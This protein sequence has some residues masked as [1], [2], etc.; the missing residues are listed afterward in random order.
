MT[1]P[2]QFVWGAATAAYQIEGATFEDGK[3]PSIWD[4][5]CRKD[6]AV[7]RGQNGDVA[8]DHYHRYAED[9]A[10]MQQIGLKAYRLSISW[11]R[12]LPNG[13]GR[14]NPKGLD[15]YDRLV[16]AL[17]AAGITPYVTL[18]HWD[19]PY[20]LYCQGGWLN[21]ASPDWFAAYTRLV[22][23][24]LGDRVQHWMTLNEPQCFIGLG[25]G[26]GRHA[27]GDKLGL[28][29]ILRAAYHALL[30]HGQSV[31]ELRAVRPDS[32]IGIAPV[33]STCF[34]N[35]ESAADIAAARQMMF[36]GARRDQ[37][38]NAWWMDPIFFGRFPADFM[39]AYGDF[40][41]EVSAAGLAT[42]HQPLDFLG[43]NI[44]TGQR[45]QAG[46]N[47][48]PEQIE[49]ATGNPITA[50]RWNVCPESL[51]WGPRFFWERYHCPIYITENGLSSMDWIALDGQVHDPLRIDHTQR[52]LLQLERAIQ[53]GVDLRGYFHWSLMDNFE[54]AEG[55]KERFGLVYVDY[56]S[57]RR[58]LKD[59]ARWYGEIIASNGARL[60][61]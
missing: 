16:D 36:D 47:G 4:M 7:W 27:P 1:F 15:F 43:L 58:I 56:P 30:A 25:H 53:D 22:A 11:P 51:Y 29:E 8:C 19:Y 35:T 23:G 40:M 44:Y 10:I 60:H 21:P 61:G 18:F 39:A 55:Y 20:D 3:G 42:I 14:P 49:E 24:R 50:F 54:W 48:A 12:L 17:L 2:E 38:N 5:F 32:R 46:A 59:S 41:P 52:Y 26:E 28:A 45:V 9:V 37:F 57:Q 31:Q 6:G 33:G 13:T 34:P